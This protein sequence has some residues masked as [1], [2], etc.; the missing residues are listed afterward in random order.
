MPIKC[1]FHRLHHYQLKH[2]ICAISLHFINDVCLKLNF[3]VF[4]S[5][6]R[7]IIPLMFALVHA[8]YTR[9]LTVHIGELL[10]SEVKTRE[11]FESF[12]K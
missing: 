9:W 6:L 11:I 7:D 8:H 5:G 10:S 2:F 12:V 3:R 4:V 1:H